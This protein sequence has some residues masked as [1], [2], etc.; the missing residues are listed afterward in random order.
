MNRLLNHWN[1]LMT[2]EPLYRNQEEYEELIR[3]S[4]D[5]RKLGMLAYESVDPETRIKNTHRFL[6]WYNWPAIRSVYGFEIRNVHDNYRFVQWFEEQMMQ[7]E[8]PQIQ[9]TWSLRAPEKE[10]DFWKWFKDEETGKPV[11]DNQDGR[12]PLVDS[13][14]TVS[15]P[16]SVP[17]SIGRESKTEKPDGK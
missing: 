12:Q 3:A 8:Q 10:E 9:H 1:G 5:V 15:P 4:E 11:F 14:P 7:T 17:R 13:R 6:E 2:Q 16:A